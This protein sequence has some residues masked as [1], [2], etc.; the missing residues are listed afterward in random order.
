MS[1]NNNNNNNNK[2]R[3]H[4]N[5]TNTTTYNNI[6][7]EDKKNHIVSKNIQ[8]EVT[9]RISCPICYEEYKS[10]LLS[11]SSTSS[12]S[13]SNNNN[14]N[15]N[16]KNINNSTTTNSTTPNNGN[17]G[18]HHS[19][20]ASM[21]SLKLIEG[22][23][24]TYEILENRHQMHDYDE[25]I[26][27]HF[28]VG[29]G[30][31]V[32][33]EEEEAMEEEN[34][35]SIDPKLNL[36]PVRST[37]CSHTICHSCLERMRLAS[38]TPNEEEYEDPFYDPQPR[39]R[40]WMT[41][42]VCASRKAF[43]SRFPTVCLTTCALIECVRGM[44]SGCCYLDDDINGK[45]Q[46]Q[47]QEQGHNGRDGGECGDVPK[48]RDSLIEEHDYHEDVDED[49]DDDDNNGNYFKLN[50][51]MFDISIMDQMEECCRVFQ[52]HG[53]KV[54][55]VRHPLEHSYD[56]SHHHGGNDDAFSP[57]LNDEE[58]FVV[59]ASVTLSRKCASSSSSSYSVG[60]SNNNNNNN[61]NNKNDNTNNPNHPSIYKWYDMEY[62]HNGAEAIAG[63]DSFEFLSLAH[64]PG[65]WVEH[66]QPAQEES[67]SYLTEIPV[68]RGIWSFY[69]YDP[70]GTVIGGADNH[71]LET[72]HD[73]D[74]NN[75]HAQSQPQPQQQPYS[76]FRSSS[77]S[78]SNN[79]YSMKLGP[80]PPPGT[81]THMS[82]VACDCKVTINDNIHHYRIQ[83]T[84]YWLIDDNID[85]CGGD[86]ETHAA[87]QH[88][89][90]RNIHSGNR[91]AQRNDRHNTHGPMRNNHNEKQPKHY[92]LGDKFELIPSSDVFTNSIVYRTSQ[93][94]TAI[95]HHSKTSNNH[96]DNEEEDNIRYLHEE[97]SSHDPS[98]KNDTPHYKTIT[99]KIPKHSIISVDMT[100][101]PK[102]FM[103]K[104]KTHSNN[105]PILCRLSNGAGWIQG[106]Y[107]THRYLDQALIQQ[108]GQWIIAASNTSHSN[109]NSSSSSDND[110]DHHHH[111]H[112]EE[113]LVHV[114]RQPI[115][116]KDLPLHKCIDYS[117]WKPPHFDA[118]VSTQISCGTKGHNNYDKEE[119]SCMTFYRVCENHGG[120]WVPQHGSIDNIHWNVIPF[121]HVDQ[122]REKFDSMVMDNADNNNN[123]NANSKP[124]ANVMSTLTTTTTP[125]SFHD[126]NYHTKHFEDRIRNSI[127]EIDQTL[128][129]TIYERKCLVR[130]ILDIE[131]AQQASFQNYHRQQ[132][133]FVSQIYQ[134]KI[135]EIEMNRK[136]RGDHLS[137]L[138]FCDPYH[139][140][141][142][143]D[144]SESDEHYGGGLHLWLDN[145]PF[146]YA[147]GRKMSIF[148][149]LEDG[150][151]KYTP[152]LPSG[153]SKLFRT[154]SLSHP[155]PIYISMGSYNRY[156]VRFENGKTEWSGK[157]RRQG[158]GQEHVITHSLK[159]EQRKIHDQQGNAN[160]NL[161][162]QA[163]NRAT[164]YDMQA[165][166][167]SN[168]VRCV[169]YG[170]SRESCIILTDD[171]YYWN[172][173]PR[174]IRD[175]LRIEN[176][177]P[178]H[179]V[180]LG[181]DG[182]YFISWKNGMFKG[183]GW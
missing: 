26:M 31:G 167:A 124:S 153:L 52:C 106:K 161:E 20:Y 158:N 50:H 41:C 132:N 32:G 48:R 35:P 79:L 15:N 81:Y 128:G 45:K 49:D 180:S 176:K 164:I 150:S 170:I 11:S 175:V 66:H 72:N 148:Q 172:D 178:I 17:Y 12:S 10:N 96:M 62:V 33:E 39:N 93:D 112:H 60:I 127:F 25:N 38:N 117:D 98:S 92:S 21:Y 5:T 29:V 181:P 145:S 8:S 154:R 87:N 134:E 179:S 74:T 136:K 88:Y 169:A 133:E 130:K 91:N 73:N 122:L 157:A 85:V 103:G 65:W 140:S 147:L 37:T 116:S 86:N 27:H 174:K 84:K 71:H 83:G 56:D 141:F 162:L 67:K 121:E 155:K 138:L 101:H 42:P 135:N 24:Y 47:E 1:N 171:G 120:G 44:R 55:L 165:V 76:S 51:E 18:E 131:T 68:M 58:I 107:C 139:P 64:K 53:G 99:W 77:S 168:T 146:H 111:H 80:F 4:E 156:Y 177:G 108:H 46:E 43:D 3:N 2:E 61:N 129:R 95:L 144:G 113:C 23:Y 6:D 109:T 94:C 36:L 183:G 9:S 123:N 34:V 166:L 173:I 22:P 105:S 7:A 149:I 104:N 59:N 159:F 30:V 142:T 90:A 78:F 119:Q 126:E 70:C 125:S 110:D 19:R 28:G 151:W 69:I 118:K 102:F 54:T 63:G 182:E 114:Y 115:L 57:F 137:Y 89:H 143:D 13:S 16:K 160:I 75:N 100:V 82:C 163:L 40:R 14:D 152:G 97:I